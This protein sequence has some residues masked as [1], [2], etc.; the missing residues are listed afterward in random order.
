[1]QNAIRRIRISRGP[2]ASLPWVYP[3]PPY[4][5]ELNPSERLWQYTRRTGRHNRY[6]VSHDELL[7][8]LTRVFGEMQAAPE[9]I[10]PYLLPFC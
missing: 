8:T 2:V 10:Q 1:M 5:P 6:F 3:L 9:I 7:A 4:S